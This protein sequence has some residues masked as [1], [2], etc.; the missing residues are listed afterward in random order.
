VRGARVRLSIE[1]QAHAA[2]VD[3]ALRRR[4]HANTSKLEELSWQR[5]EVN[6]IIKVP[7][8]CFHRVILLE[9]RLRLTRVL[10]ENKRL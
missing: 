2:K 4:L 10:Y 9:R 1:S 5:E 7:S 8:T 6:W 3:A